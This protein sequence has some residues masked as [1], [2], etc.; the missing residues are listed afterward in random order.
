MASEEDEELNQLDHKESLVVHNFKDDGKLSGLDVM[1]PAVHGLTT[2]ADKIE[3]VNS[4]E[5]KEIEEITIHETENLEE[6]RE[7]GYH[8]TH[9]GDILDGRFEVVHKISNGSYGLVWLC[10]EL[11]S[12]N[13]VAIKILMAEDSEESSA[14]IQITQ[15]LRESGFEPEDWEA[16]H[17]ALP[18]ECFWVNGPN[19]THK[20]QV[21]P[22]VGLCVAPAMVRAEGSIIKKLM[23]QVATGLQFLHKKTGFVHG[24]LQICNIRLKLR[25]IT[26]MSKS[27]MLR[28]LGKPEIQEVRTLS[29]KHLGAAFPRYV[30]GAVSLL[31]LTAHDEIA[32][33]DFAHG[34]KAG[35]PDG[36][37]WMPLEYM[38]PEVAFSVPPL[39]FGIDNWA[40]ACITI[41]LRVNRTL[42]GDKLSSYVGNLEALLSPLPASCRPAFIQ[43]VNET[44]NNFG[45]DWLN[46]WS[47]DLNETGVLEPMCEP[48]ELQARKYRLRKFSTKTGFSDP[49]CAFLASEQHCYAAS[50]IKSELYQKTYKV[51]DEEARVLGDL[52]KQIFRY[53]PNERL[54]IDGIVGHE[55]F[56]SIEEPHQSLSTAAQRQS[57]LGKASGRSDKN[58][59]RATTC[60]S[61]SV[62][63]PGERRIFEN[64]G[65]QVKDI[66]GSSFVDAPEASKSAKSLDEKGSKNSAC[67]SFEVPPWAKPFVQSHSLNPILTGAF[68][69]VALWAWIL[70]LIRGP[71]DSPG[72]EI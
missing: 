62:D 52:V 32:I 37:A 67:P 9:I 8:P 54:E 35:D 7:G 47:E 31:Q 5:T 72:S 14:D 64:P 24:Q 40:L 59:E 2:E 60:S 18:R 44:R 22:F 28:R 56:H 68:C 4:E 70:S 12:G 11:S 27:D 15:L 46:G 29:G 26:G 30:V 63:E 42:F 48:Q 57:P 1:I 33:I 43:A 41:K 61:G 45:S 16:Y 6:Y 58:L 51:P 55:W 49:L 38:A 53:E 23:L 39:G 13:W 34:F 21:L 10:L 20:A 71:L 50:P 66:M 3:I 65:Q 19:G 69:G 25:N 17:L 36:E